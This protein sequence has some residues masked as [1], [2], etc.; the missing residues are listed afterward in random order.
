MPWT[1]LFRTKIPGDIERPR[2]GVAVAVALAVDP[3][4]ALGLCVDQGEAVDLRDNRAF[5]SPPS[6]SEMLSR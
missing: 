3:G 5:T 6:N 4:A 2:Q 1:R